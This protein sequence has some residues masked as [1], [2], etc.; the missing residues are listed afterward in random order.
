MRSQIISDGIENFDFHVYRKAESEK[1]SK[2]ILSGDYSPQKCQR[3]LLEKSKGLCRQIVVPSIR[4]V[5]VLQCLSDALY[6]SLKGKAPTKKSFFEPKDHSFSDTGNTYG[7]YRAWLNFQ[8]AL[9]NFS[10]ARR[11]IVVTDIANYYDSIN[12]NYLRNSIS[13]ISDVDECVIDMLIYVLSDLL[14]QPDYTPRMEVGLPQ[15]NLDAPRVLAHAFL[16]EL[17]SFLDS[18]T[19]ID[20]VRY[21]D[22]VDIGV[23]TIVDAKMILKSV[24]LVL[25]ARQV[26]LNSGKT[27]ILSQAQASQHFCIAENAYLDNLKSRID[28]KIKAGLPLDSERELVKKCIHR[29]L[30]RGSFDKGNGEK[31]LKRW[32]GLA[33][34]VGTDIAPQAVESVI[35]YRPSVRENMLTYLRGRPLTPK[36]AEALYNCMSSGLLMDDAA[37]V[38]ISN[39]LA[40]TLCKN[41]RCNKFI[42]NIIDS[43]DI[44]STYGLYCKIWMQ[45]KYS[46]IDDLMKTV[47]DSIKVWAPDEPIGR[48]VGSLY[49]LFYGTSL[50][51]R[52]KR[53]IAHSLNSGARDAYKFQSR[54]SDD[55]Y[56]L[57]EMIPALRSPNPTRGTGIT[58]AKFLCLVS[59]LNNRNANPAHLKTLRD[60]NHMAFSDAYYKDIAKRTGI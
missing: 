23:D 58:H 6:A 21:M 35:K 13:S 40:E 12:Y 43:F 25:Q 55:V 50:I 34:K 7:T 29:D 1:L 45:S 33:A 46:T 59:A 39:H 60:A 18:N 57:N 27:L 22:D 5:I 14:W 19:H 20:F 37:N 44:T 32:I 15:I 8:R 9:F 24:D 51:D 38:H 56:V 53:V 49:P 11:Y 2:M 26:R 36:Y 52:Y 16:Y 54:L 42:I 31:I 48:L 41:K 3:I 47:S 4:D 30:K 17:D 10:K 28:N